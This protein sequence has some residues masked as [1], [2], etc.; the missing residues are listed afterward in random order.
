MEYSAGIVCYK[1][2]DN[3][4]IEIM[5]SH[6]GGPYYDGLDDHSWTIQKGKIEDK[7]T[8]EEA[9]R[10]E[11][12]E[13]TGFR[14]NCRIRRLGSFKVSKS[15]IVTVFFTEKDFDAK[16][17]RSNTFEMEWPKDSGEI[18]SYPENDKAEWFSI[19]EAHNKIFY[20]Q[21]QILF[22]LQ[23]EIERLES[24]PYKKRNVHRKKKGKKR[25]KKYRCFYI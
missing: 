5:L 13:E 1:K 4:N 9:A 25:K 21:E 10:R 15:K 23:E 14:I 11:F 6:A 12:H 18:H 2:N 8:E 22:R 19:E 17:A 7:E 16:N 3:G 20:G 24:Q